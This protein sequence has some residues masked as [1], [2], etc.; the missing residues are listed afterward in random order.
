MKSLEAHVRRFALVLAIALAATSALAVAASMRAPHYGSV[1]A[2]GVRL[3]VMEQGH[4]PTVIFVHGSLS[5]YTYWQ[6]QIPAF[7]ARY[8]VIGYSRRYNFP[9]DN[10]ARRGYSAIVDA[11]DLAAL[12][13]VRRL[14]PVSSVTPTAP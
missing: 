2:N 13:R 5:D 8:H 14:G 10:P 9:D 6:G 11:E 3:H 4:G 7:A 12:I 1:V